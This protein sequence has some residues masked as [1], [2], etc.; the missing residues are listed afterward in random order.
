[1]GRPIHASRIE[2]SMQYELNVEEVSTI[3]RK[4]HFTVDANEVRQELDRAFRELSKRVR[5]PGFRPGKVPR[6]M[7]EARFGAQ[8]RGEVG[9]RLIELSYREA[10]GDLKVTGQPTVEEQGEVNAKDALTFTIQVDVHPEVEVKDHTG[11]AIDMPVAKIGPADV[12]RAIANRLASQ[13]RIEEVGDDRPVTLGDLVVTELTLS[14]DGEEL[15]NEAGTMIHT[16]AERYYPGVEAELIGMKTD[17]SKTVE[18]TIGDQTQYEH[19][20]GVSCTATLKIISIQAHT[21]PPLDDESA[22]ALGFDDAKSMTAD[23][24]EQLNKYAMDTGRNQARVGIL[25]KLVESNEFDIPQGM[26]DEQLSALVDEL[27][28][29]QTYMGKDPKDLRFT[30]PEIDDLKMRAEFAAR[31]SAILTAVARQ[32]NIAVDDEELDG[33]IAEIAEQQGQ[34]LEAIKAYVEQQGAAEIMRARVLEEK[35]LDWLLDHAK[36]TEVEPPPPEEIAALGADAPGWNKG[37]KKGELLD[38]AKAMGIEVNT[39]MT[40]ATLIEALENAG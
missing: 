39:K 1:M 31:S 30:D 11:V 29:R 22:K 2:D 14:K 20:S 21:V 35:T 34:P 19:L 25:E 28:S 3:S 13:A 37:M 18:L 38:V 36:V 5:L 15:A 10:S 24:E 26:I 17:E 7:L 4:L 27:R 12:D 23:I 8:V 9:G 16:T 40:K 33:K 32:E 6:N